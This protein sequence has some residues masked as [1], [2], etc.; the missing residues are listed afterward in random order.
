[1]ESLQFIRNNIYDTINLL[2]NDDNNVDE[3]LKNKFYSI[4]FIK[5]SYDNILKNYENIEGFDKKRELNDYELLSYD[6]IKNY[7]D[8]FTNCSACSIRR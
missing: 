5:S 8:N 4:R 7:L 2:D 3:T 1:M 6:K